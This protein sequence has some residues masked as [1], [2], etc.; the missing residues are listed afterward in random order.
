MLSLNQLKEKMY[1][2]V[3]ILKIERNKIY[4]EDIFIEG[5][6]IVVVYHSNRIP[7]KTTTELY[8]F[9]ERSFIYL[10][11]RNKCIIYKLFYVD[12]LLRGL[13]EQRKIDTKDYR[14]IIESE[15]KNDFH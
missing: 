7:V 11:E 15:I 10:N 8:E 14:I 4:I 6:S 5:D 2:Y 12:C 9:Y 3:D 1:Y 13:I